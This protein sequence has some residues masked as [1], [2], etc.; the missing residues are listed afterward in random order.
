M[1][2]RTTAPPKDWVKWRSN[3]VRPH[4]KVAV[5]TPTRGEPSQEFRISFENMRDLDWQHGVR[6]LGS[7][8]QNWRI[9]AIAGAGVTRVRNTIAHKFL[10]LEHQPEWLLMIDDDMGFPADAL[11]MLLANATPERIIGG[12]CFAWG[13][14]GLPIPT[15]FFRD[16]CGRHQ[17]VPASYEVPENTLVEVAGTGAAFLLVHRDA[18]I[19]IAKLMPDSYHPW[20]RDLE[21]QVV[22]QETGEVSPHWVSEDLFFCDQA[23]RAGLKVFVNTA[24][25]VTHRKTILLTEGLYDLMRT[26]PPQQRSALE[27]A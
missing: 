3:L 19:A 9:D 7:V 5:A 13:P 24:I 22:N 25:K 10:H 14:E 6:R 27:W 4:E 20:F 12:L 16:E 26:L 11:E 2:G 23:A 21:T 17:P 8:E 18:L 1:T 15:I